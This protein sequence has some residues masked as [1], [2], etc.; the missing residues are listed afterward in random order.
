MSEPSLARRL[1]GM[2]QPL[3]QGVRRLYPDSVYVSRQYRFR[4][5][6]LPDLRDPRDLSEKVQWLKLHDRSA[7][8]T[9]CADKIRARGYVA[10]RL[11]PDRLV[12]ALLITHDPEDIRPETVRA[13][14]FVVK[15]NHDQG[16]V[17]ICRDRAAF[18]WAGVRAEVARRFKLNKYPEYREWQYKDIRPGVLVEDFVEAGDGANVHELKFYCFHG[19][20]RYVQ[21]VLDRFEDRREGFYDPDWRRMPFM[22]P[23]AQLE[24]DVPCPPCLERLLDDARVLSE[25]FLFCRIDF[26]HGGGERA[27]FGEVTFHH[28]AG[29]IRFEPPEWERALGDMIDLSRL[30]ET[31]RIQDAVL[32]AARAPGPPAG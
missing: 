3:R 9:L 17:F 22:A 16:G 4:N 10:A 19:E 14:R 7:L 26:L 28:G 2:T 11:G 31:R 32:K 21:V 5:G 18:D 20:P 25:P 27:W 12:P 24:R 23:V 1:W 13:E 8:H 6:V 30:G 29:L 15:T